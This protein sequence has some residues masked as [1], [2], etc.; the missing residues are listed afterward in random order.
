MVWAS[1]GPNTSRSDLVIMKCDE[2]SQGFGFI[3]TLYLKT[4]E[5]GLIPIYNGEIFRQDI[6]LIHTARA[7]RTWFATKGIYLMPGWPL[8]SPDCNH[9]EHLWPR[10]KELV[11]D[12]NPDLDSITNKEAQ[13]RALVEALRIV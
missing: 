2:L 9:I 12:V 7:A 8:Y 6:A 5:E 13:Q 10:L 1:V 4:L 11:Y 3:S